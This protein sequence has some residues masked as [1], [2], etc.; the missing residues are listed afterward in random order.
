[1]AATEVVVGGSGRGETWKAQ[2]AMALVQVSFGGYHVITKVARSQ[3]WR[4]P[5][6]LLPL[7]RRPCPFN[8]RASCLLP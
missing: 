1:M 4:K 2:A 8:S 7:P 3:C 5:I 6:R